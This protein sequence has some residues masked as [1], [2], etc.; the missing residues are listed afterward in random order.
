MAGGHQKLGESMGAGAPSQPQNQPCRH[1]DRDCCLRTVT[2]V[3]LLCEARCLRFEARCV[4]F[5]ARCVRCGAR[6]V[7]CGAHCV[8]CEAHC[9]RCLVRSPRTPIQCRVHIM[10]HTV[11]V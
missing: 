10:T 1:R 9:L 8:R 6:C 3:F 11:F 4:R 2:N 7:R 5:E